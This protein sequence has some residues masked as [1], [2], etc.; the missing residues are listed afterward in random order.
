M[1]IKY[2]QIAKKSFNCAEKYSKYY[3]CYFCSYVSY[4]ERH[5]AQDASS[6]ETLL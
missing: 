5:V 4:V 1:I 3:V 6:L 2:S